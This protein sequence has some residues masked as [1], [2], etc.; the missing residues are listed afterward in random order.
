M[1]TKFGSKNAD[2]SYELLSDGRRHFS[3]EFNQKVG[4]DWRK[5]V[6]LVR[7]YGRRT[8][9]FLLHDEPYGKFKQYWIVKDGEAPPAGEPKSTVA[10]G[11]GD[12]T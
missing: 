8:G 7:K 1:P 10:Y 12:E 5:A 4:W 11:P 9:E 3:H 2:A 6:S